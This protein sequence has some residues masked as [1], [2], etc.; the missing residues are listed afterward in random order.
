MCRNAI[1]KKVAKI[2]GRIAQSIVS[3]K[4]SENKLQRIFVFRL[5]NNI[6]TVHTQKVQFCMNERP[7][8]IMRELLTIKTHFLLDQENINFKFFKAIL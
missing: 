1:D 3:H 6:H 8:T 2:W 5:E 7:T 4:S